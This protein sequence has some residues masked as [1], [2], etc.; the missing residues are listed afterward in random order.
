MTTPNNAGALCRLIVDRAS[1][2]MGDDVSSHQEVWQLPGSTSIA[3]LLTIMATQFL[4]PVAGYAGWRVYQDT[5]ERGPGWTLGLVY[6]QDH[7]RQERYVCVQGQYPPTVADLT[8]RAPALVIQADYLSGS[9]A[10][11]LWL[12]EITARHSFTGVQPLRAALESDDDA[13]RDWRVLRELNSIAAEREGPR[14]EWVRDRITSGALAGA[15]LFAARHIGAVYGDLC[16][17]S[18]DLATRDLLG[19]DSDHDEVFAALPQAE[20]ALGVVAAVFGAFEWGL[21]RGLRRLRPAAHSVAYLEFLAAQGYSLAPIEQ[22]L[23]GH[24]DFAGLAG[25]V[26]NAVM[27][28]EQGVE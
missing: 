19:V 16:P 4:P 2:C 1:V 27:G 24:I 18:M 3:E 12:S 15:E 20:A 28:R 13:G 26:G 11:P 6:C 5:G 7:L 21:P 8:R 14:R 22:F 25:T 10:R 17:A 9:V 23:A